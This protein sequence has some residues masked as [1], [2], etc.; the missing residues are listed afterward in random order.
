[1]WVRDPTNQSDSD[2][3][4]ERLREKKGGFLVLKVLSIYQSISKSVCH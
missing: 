2:I 3:E 1:M 4:R